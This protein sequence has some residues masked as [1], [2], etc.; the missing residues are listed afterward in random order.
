[1]FA[2]SAL[3]S[4]LFLTSAPVRELFLTFL[5]VIRD[6]ASAGPPRATNSEVT[7][8]PVATPGGVDALHCDSRLSGFRPA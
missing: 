4:E 3:V 7:A 8:M 2:T 5:P 1:M 6:A